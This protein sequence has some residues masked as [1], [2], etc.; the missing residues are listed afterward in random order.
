MAMNDR[1]QQ[2]NDKIHLMTYL[3]TLIHFLWFMYQNTFSLIKWAGLLS[4][5][6]EVRG[7]YYVRLLQL[8]S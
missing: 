4:D 8:A 5:A 6:H 3:C 1:M 2:V 7:D